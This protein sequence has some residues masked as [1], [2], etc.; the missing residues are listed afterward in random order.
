MHA[1]FCMHQTSD[2]CADVCM[3]DH[4]HQMD[5][6]EIDIYSIDKLLLCMKVCLD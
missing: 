3:C 2:T 1:I 5:K 4:T 6:T